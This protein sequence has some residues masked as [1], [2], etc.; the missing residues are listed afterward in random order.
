MYKYNVYLYI[1]VSNCTRALRL[2]HHAMR[3]AQWSLQN[4]LNGLYEI[5]STDCKQY[6][7]HHTLYI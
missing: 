5:C 6:K 4:L 3:S 7:L 1:L 2:Q